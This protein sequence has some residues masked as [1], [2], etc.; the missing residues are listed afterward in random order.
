MLYTIGWVEVL[1]CKKRFYDIKNRAKTGFP[2]DLLAASAA[3]RSRPQVM[4]PASMGFE[5]A[6]H[7]AGRIMSMRETRC[8]FMQVGACGVSAIP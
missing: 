4:V 6:R 5:A 7:D 8:G 2:V 1:F 3:S